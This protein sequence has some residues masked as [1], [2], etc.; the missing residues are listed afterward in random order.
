M[1]EIYIVT[2]LTF[3]SFYIACGNGTT[4]QKPESKMTTSSSWKFMTESGCVSPESIVGKKVTPQQMIATGCVKVQEKGPRMILDCRDV[5]DMKKLFVM[6]N[7][8]C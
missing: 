2:V 5:P 1:K 8:D 3:V 4:E 7:E 6:T